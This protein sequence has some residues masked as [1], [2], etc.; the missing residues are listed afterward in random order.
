M[1]QLNDKWVRWIGLPLCLVLANLIYLEEYN[2]NVWLFFGW[3]ALGWIYIRIIWVGLDRWRIWT[4]QR[5]TDIAQT[6]KRVSVSFLGYVV[7]TGSA[8]IA[9]IALT[10]YTQTAPV[11]VT[12]TVLA[13]HLGIGLL[14][15]SIFGTAYEVFYFLQKYRQAVEEAEVVQLETLQSQFDQLMNQVN[16]HFLFNSLN[17]LSAL[18]ATDKSGAN[19]FLEELAAVY[20]YLL[21][22]NPMQL[23]SL[24]SEVGFFES[25]AHILQVRYGNALNLQIQ[26]SPEWFEAYLPPCSLHLLVDNAIRHNSIQVN[27]P[28]R[29]AITTTSSCPAFNGQPALVVT[30]TIQRKALRVDNRPGGLHQLTERFALLTLPDPQIADDGNQFAVTLPLSPKPTT[31]S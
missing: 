17:S 11:P 9:F 8:Q 1:K 30:N 2:Y 7:I 24:R 25:L 28:L 13:T 19:A 12:S 27:Q 10:A 6:P 26:V 3:V 4:R 18:I 15:I 29:I 21:Q 16:P 31:L 22:S 5:Y 23:T 14:A 20:R